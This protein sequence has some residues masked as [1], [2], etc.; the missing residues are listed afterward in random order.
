MNIVNSSNELNEGFKEFISQQ[1][2]DLVYEEMT[3]VLSICV[4]YQRVLADNNLVLQF[5][6]FR[7]PIE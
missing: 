5:L 4:K 3:R 1:R 6:G 2:V 7:Q